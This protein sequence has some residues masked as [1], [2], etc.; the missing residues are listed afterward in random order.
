MPLLSDRHHLGLNAFRAASSLLL[1]QCFILIGPTWRW[2]LPGDA[3]LMHYVVFLIESGVAPYRSIVDM[4]MPGTY[5]S[6]W[7]VMHVFGSGAHAWRVWDVL[8]SL[9]SIVGMTRI[10]G[11]PRRHAG[12]TAGC[13][14]MLLH[15]QDGIPHAG[16]RDLLMTSLMLLGAGAILSFLRSQANVWWL[17]LAGALLGTSIIIK[18]TAALFGVLLMTYAYSIQRLRARSCRVPMAALLFGVLCPLLA[19]MALLIRWG[20]VKAFWWT[21]THLIPLEALFGRRPLAYFI[22]HGLA[23]I[24]PVG[25]L[26]VILA[27]TLIIAIQKT[28]CSGRQPLSGIKSVVSDFYQHTTAVTIG[29]GVLC[30]FISYLAQGKG[31]PYHRYP[32][33]AFSLLAW[34]LISM[35]ALKLQTPSRTLKLVLNSLSIAGLLYISF[36]VGPL[37]LVKARS[38]KPDDPFTDMLSADLQSLGGASLS[39]QIQCVDMSAGCLR[40]LWF[41]KLKQSTGTLYEYTFLA[42]VEPSSEKALRTSFADHLRKRLPEVFVVTDQD[43]LFGE[44]GYAKLLRWP[45]L[46]GLLE[47]D[48]CLWAQR[49]PKAK[50]Q[51]ESPSASPSGYRI[52]RLKHALCKAPINP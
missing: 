48:Y 24:Q 29:L 30:G 8:L 2:P 42:P 20:S 39:G 9:L 49:Q 40:T 15:T 41:L 45:Y 17:F 31:Y 28:G 52:Y 18:P 35:E 26:S 32:L 14:F 38:F 50:L 43:Y 23:P 47:S 33:L 12:V 34:S 10:A 19:T 1:L 21:L 37:A 44:Q 13:V 6:E 7:F 51:W 3:S 46:A 11:I 5:A 25:Y 27:I 22:G 36:A 4:N 16:Q